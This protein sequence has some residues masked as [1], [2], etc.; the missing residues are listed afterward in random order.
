MSCQHPFA[1]FRG[2]K[3]ENIQ[4]SYDASFCPT[5]CVL[6]LLILEH[7]LSATAGTYSI[8]YGTQERRRGI[9]T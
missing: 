1:D 8:L 7:F 3:Y 4:S 6:Y 9:N 5:L 2:M